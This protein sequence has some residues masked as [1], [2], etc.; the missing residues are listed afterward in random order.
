MGS[1]PIMLKLYFVA[2][3]EIKL[4]VHVLNKCDNLFKSEVMTIGKAVIR[5]RDDIS[6]NFLC[7]IR[8][9]PLTNL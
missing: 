1:R 4:V 3:D 6:P 9:Y 2:R 5:N 8:A 7:V